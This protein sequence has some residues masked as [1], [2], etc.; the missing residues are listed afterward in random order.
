MRNKAL[1]IAALVGLLVAGMIGT[2][3]AAEIAQQA[4]TRFACA[5]FQGEAVTISGTV[6]GQS[7]NKLTVASGGTDY[8]VVTGPYKTGV[9]L[10][11]FAANESVTVEG[12][13]GMMEN[14]PQGEPGANVIVAKTITRQDG[15]VIDLTQITGAG[16]QGAAGC[17]NRAAGS[18]GQQVRGRGMAGGRGGIGGM[19]GGQGCG[20]T[21]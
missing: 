11:E 21:R 20:R 14:C 13:A 9:N 8:T 5:N 16:G 3:F 1:W 19:M 6:T 18:N 4:R 7:W 12:F 17:G 10:P 15:S 2:A